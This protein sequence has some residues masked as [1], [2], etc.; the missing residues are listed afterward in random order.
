MFEN[1]LHQG[2]KDEKTGSYT[3]KVDGKE[4]VDAAPLD[5]MFLDE[6]AKKYSK[7]GKRSISHAK[8]EY[9]PTA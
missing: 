3:F 7:E 6:E 2:V 5:L 8:T 9:D 4:L 1:G